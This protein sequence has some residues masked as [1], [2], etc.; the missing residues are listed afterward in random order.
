MNEPTDLTVLREI[1]DG[2]RVHPDARIGAFCTIGPDAVIGPRT[3]LGPRATVLGRTIIGSDNLI[4][5]GC[6]LGGAPQDLKYRGRPTYLIV[7]DGNRLGPN[8]TA[9][10]GTEPGG[11]LTRIGDGNVL[12][13]G[14]HVA[15]DCYVENRTHLGPGVLLGGH[16]RIEDGAVIE[17][18]V[19]V[20]QFTTIGRHSR[21]GARTPVRR[22]VPPFTFFASTDYYDTP[23][24]T[25]G[26][27]EQGLESAGLSED[28]KRRLRRAF[29]RLFEDEQAL[30]T[31]IRSLLAEGEPGWA[32]RTLCEFCQRSLSGTFGRHRETLRGKMP[33]EA[34]A[35][36][37]PEALVEI[38][39][40]EGETGG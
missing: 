33:P 25:R 27:H 20:H 13:A 28:Q 9:H 7:G 8:V 22:D 15:H 5:A 32:V 18:M 16:V 40:W 36:L 21:V 38:A 26:V 29:V 34:A 2:A 1:A 19:G 39:S 6:V 4:Q 17:E 14:A 12:D 10:L 30:S 31:K 35:Y 24:D 3:V 23:A 11:Y 37:P